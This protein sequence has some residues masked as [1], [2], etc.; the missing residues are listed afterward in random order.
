MIILV[1]YYLIVRNTLFCINSLYGCLSL[2][3]TPLSP[4]MVVTTAMDD[5]VKTPLICE[6]CS[7]SVNNRV[8]QIDLICLPL[9]KVDIVLGKDWLYTNL[10]FIGCEDK[11]III[12][13]SEVTLKD[14]LTIV[15]E[16]MVGMVNYM[17]EKEKHVLLVLVKELSNDLKVTQIPIIYEFP[18]V[19]PKDVTSLPPKRKVEFSIDLIPETAPIYVSLYHM[20]M[21]ELR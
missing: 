8:L 21:L 20:A 18:E 1:L 12:P 14:V 5:I 17:F 9:K 2:K 19:F 15:L 13:S 3:S 10:V 7:M 11:M 4:P 16:G 6:N